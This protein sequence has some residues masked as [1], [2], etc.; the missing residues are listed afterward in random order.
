MKKYIFPFAAAFMMASCKTA[1]TVKP[2]TDTTSN[3]PIDMKAPVSNAAFF[4]AVNK[5]PGFAQV[6]INSKINVETGNYIPQTDATIYIENGQKIWMNISAAFLNVARGVATPQGIKG[7]EKITKSYIESDFSYLNKLLNVNFINYDSFQNLLLGKTLAPVKADEFTLTQNAQGFNLTSVE[8]KKITSN[9]RTSEYRISLDYAP[10]YDLNH[11]V[12]QDVRTADNL[13][14][15]Y[16]NWA[17]FGAERFPQNVKIILKGQ[18]TGQI[19]IENTKF[20]F[21][22]METPYSVPSNYTKKEIR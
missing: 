15:Y 19:L 1:T 20:D 6:K 9:G 12:L 14:V 11:V 22:K 4:D 5:K 7:Y 10:N 16:S 18:K 3:K 2:V 13:E 21:S 17:G 8:N